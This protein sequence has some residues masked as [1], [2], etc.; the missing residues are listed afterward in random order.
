MLVF[1]PQ[2]KQA[3]LNRPIKFGTIVRTKDSD[4]VVMGYREVP[5]PL[6]VFQSGLSIHLH[7]HLIRARSCRAS[8]GCLAHFAAIKIGVTGMEQPSPRSMNGNTGV[9]PGMAG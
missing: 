1:G 4:I 3:P 6:L 5:E 7:H 2:S 8:P 9:S